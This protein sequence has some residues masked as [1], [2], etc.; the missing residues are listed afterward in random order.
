VDVELIAGDMAAPVRGRRFDLV[1]SN[2]PFVVGP[3]VATHTYRD[4]GRS[5]DALSAELAG[6]AADLLAEGG[7]CQYLANWLHLAGEDWTERVA[8]WVAGTGLDAWVI[9]REVSDPVSYVDLWLSDAGE[10]SDPVRAAAWLDWFDA[11]E[12][13]AVGM[14]LITLRR[15]GHDDPV[16]RVEELRQAIDQPLGAQISAWLDRQDWLRGRD[17]PALLHQ[18]YRAAKGLI[19]AQQATIG[20]EGWAVDRQ[21][22]TLPAGLRWSEEVDPLV[23]A[24]VGGCD[25]TVPLGDQ[26]SVLAVAHEV[27]ESTLA[28]VAGPIVAHLVERGFIEPVT[29]SPA[30]SAA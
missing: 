16:V 21:V 13:D 11:N 23:L 8:G 27:E 1:V 9:Q 26:L 5:G 25:G 22:L 30:V 3:G 28:D 6:A 4:S 20:A 24:L 19:L 15:G 18:R 17:T 2:P 14:G 12:V 7:V 29:A 10:R